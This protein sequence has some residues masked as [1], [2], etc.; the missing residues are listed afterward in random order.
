MDWLEAPLLLTT[1]RTCELLHISAPTL[2][3][4]IREGKLDAR[5]QGSRT[6]ILA[7][8]VRR[9]V[10]QLPS[11]DLNRGP[12]RIVAKQALDEQFIGVAAPLEQPPP[13]RK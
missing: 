9:Y 12:K 2:Y 1:G 10:E 4:L 6:V 7:E 8:S 11:A 13:R 3:S 5:E